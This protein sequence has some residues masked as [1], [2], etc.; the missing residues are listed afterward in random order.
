M[1]SLID[2]YTKLYVI[3]TYIILIIRNYYVYSGLP[4]ADGQRRRN[5][6]PK[7]DDWLF[8]YCVNSSGYWGRNIMR[9][10]STLVKSGCGTCKG[11]IGAVAEMRVKD[12]GTRVRSLCILENL[13]VEKEV[14]E[15]RQKN[16]LGSIRTK[17]IGWRLMKGS[18]VQR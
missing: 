15:Q 11:N 17:G 12:S 3:T 16:T 7:T 13:L 2:G 14:K 4:G 8:N 10:W 1:N 6:D 9:V 18:L 5:K